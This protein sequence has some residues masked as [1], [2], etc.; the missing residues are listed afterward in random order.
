MILYLLRHGHAEDGN[1]KP[2]HQRELTPQG[3]QQLKVTA[4]VLQTLDLGVTHAFTSPR[5]RAEQTMQQIAP[6]LGV[7][8]TVHEGVNFSFSVAVLQHML[9]DFDRSAR[10]LLVGHNPSMS[11]VV[12]DL[13]GAIVSMRKGGLARIDMLSW[14][15]PRG[16][17]VWL[18]APKVF[19]ALAQ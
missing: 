14:S 1:G 19:D 16:E 10:V 3:I 6:T 18:L 17:L 4:R 11:Q 7:E 13:T 12:G 8:Y 5:I 15:P 2:D 9:A